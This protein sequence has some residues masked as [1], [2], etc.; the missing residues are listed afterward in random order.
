MGVCPEQQAK[1][2]K[3]Y[4]TATSF[5]VVQY[6]CFLLDVLHHLF[7]LSKTF[8]RKTVSIAEVHS[9]LQ[10][11][12]AVLEKYK[13]RDGS[14]LQRLDK[15]PEFEQVRLTR[16]GSSSSYPDISCWMVF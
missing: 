13:E 10:V 16:S 15:A 7:N 8:Q 6:A 4:K 11:T 3:Y 9:S 14:M 12:R 1:S 2:R 5:D